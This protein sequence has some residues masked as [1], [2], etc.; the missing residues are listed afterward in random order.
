METNVKV[1]FGAVAALLVYQ[2]LRI[3]KLT[4]FSEHIHEGVVILMKEA[5]NRFQDRVDEIFEDIVERYD[6]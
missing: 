5:D 6:D 3:R 1:G 4:K 2:A